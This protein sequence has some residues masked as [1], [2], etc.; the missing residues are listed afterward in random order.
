MIKNICK[1]AIA[2]EGGI[3]KTSLMIKLKTGKFQPDYKMTIGTNIFVHSTDIEAERQNFL[4]WDFAGEDRFRFLLNSFVRG[5][6]AVLLCFDLS[7]YSSFKKLDEW[8]D[9]IINNTVNPVIF[10]IG[11]KSDVKRT[12]RKKEIEEWKHGKVIIE[13]FECSAVTGKNVMEI[14]TTLTSQ[15][16][17]KNKEG[18]TSENYD[19]K[20]IL[21]INT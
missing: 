17:K 4:I 1:C 14:F 2:G 9:L 5:S 16:T 15:I 13:Y 11:T 3:G 6:A 20:D 12:V 21:E 8:Y 7:R 10:L 19:C 18:Y